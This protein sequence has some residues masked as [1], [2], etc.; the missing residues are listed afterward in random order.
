[1]ELERLKRQ[2][3]KEDYQLSKQMFDTERENFIKEKTKLEE[4][5]KRLNTSSYGQ[6]KMIEQEV[7]RRIQE[8]M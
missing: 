6:E 5:A 1:L 4:A 2:S 8:M 3:E 7:Q